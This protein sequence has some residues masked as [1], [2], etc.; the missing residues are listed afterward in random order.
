MVGLVPAGDHRTAIE[1]SWHRCRNE[2]RL[3]QRA[4]SASLRL[5]TEEVRHRAQALRELLCE[6]LSLIDELGDLAARAGN[7]LVLTDRDNILIDFRARDGTDSDFARHGIALGSNWDERIAGTNGVALARASG[8]PF[9]V[10]G[11][12]HFYEALKAFACTAVP[13][14]DAEDGLLGAINISMVDRGS[15]SDY[16][17]AQHIL[18]KAADRLQAVLFRKR[19]AERVLMRVVT[20]THGGVERANALLSLDD[21]GR[22]MAAT[23][24]AAEALGV[25]R[26]SDLLG[27]AVHQVEQIA[28]APSRPHAAREMGR[29]EDDRIRHSRVVLETPV[30]PRR[31]PAGRYVR[32]PGVAPRLAA[33]LASGVV[34]GFEL[35]RTRRLMRAGLPVLITGPIGSGK[36]TLAS[37][38]LEE[39]GIGTGSVAYIDGRSA[40][41]MSRSSFETTVA[42]AER[43]GACHGPGAL[44][45]EN[46]FRLDIDRQARLAAIIGG[47]LCASTKRN[48]FHL[49]AICNESDFA[50]ASNSSDLNPLVPLLMTSALRLRSID[51]HTRIA[52]IAAQILDEV[53][54]GR[55][56][57]SSEAA[58]LLQTRTWVG[59]VRELAVTLAQAAACCTGNVLRPEH[60][61]QM[62]PG[63]VGANSG[64][65]SLEQALAF[66]N[67]NVTLAARLMGISRA[68]INRRIA[69]AGLVRPERR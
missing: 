2:F 61:P 37:T 32:R 3:V 49:V 1:A 52:P 17:F 22:V 19:H 51:E 26:V 4:S 63:A 65:K 64:P 48:R 39:V 35:D 54:S 58:A 31:S 16:V 27:K 14:L 46:A 41:A 59:E 50:T 11:Q 29:S 42:D 44:I 6:Q 8:R 20:P 13:L 34:D 33:A 30:I 24:A 5:R 68:T 40:E 28:S 60:L 53:S 69:Q 10:R 9:T 55:L 36:T 38:L 66:S 62:P 15:S 43:G 56:R 25:T 47:E 21:A 7:C 23:S 57:L 12:D 45:L 67:W 18:G